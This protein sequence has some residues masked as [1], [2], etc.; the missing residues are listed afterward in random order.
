MRLQ[1]LENG[2]FEIEARDLGALLGLTEEE[3]RRRMEAGRITTRIE[4]GLGEDEGRFRVTFTHDDGWVRLVL[5][6]GGKVL[7]SSRIGGTGRPGG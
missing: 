5:D 4:R 6:A 7:K 2:G 1:P 3:V